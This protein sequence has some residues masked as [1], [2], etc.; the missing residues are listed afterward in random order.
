MIQLM[1][2]RDSTTPAWFSLGHMYHEPC[3]FSQSAGQLNSNHGQF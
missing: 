1:S 3:S 2:R